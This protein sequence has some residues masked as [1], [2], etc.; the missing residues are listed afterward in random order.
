MASDVVGYFA[1]MGTDEVGTMSAMRELRKEV[2]GPKVDEYGGRVV[3][4]TGDDQLTEFPKQLENRLF[5]RLD[6]CRGL[7]ESSFG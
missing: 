4:L 3:K 6:A 1:L 7:T 5:H 2:W